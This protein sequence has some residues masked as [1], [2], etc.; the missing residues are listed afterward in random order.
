[1]LIE[2]ENK[3]KSL[4]WELTTTCNY[5]CSYCPD[6]AHD[7]KYRWP[8]KKH[9]DEILILIKKFSD[10]DVPL[11][12]DLLGGE[13]TLWPELPYFIS[14]LN[15]MKL[16]IICDIL[17]NGSRSIKWWENNVKL[18]DSVS[19]GLSFH[20]EYAK[21]DHFIEVI[22]ILK[23]TAYVYTRILALP[24]KWDIGYNFYTDAV[25]TIKTNLDIGFKFV[26]VNFGEE[27]YKYTKKQNDI[28]LS[29]SVNSYSRKL[30]E[31]RESFDISIDGEIYKWKYIVS[32]KLNKWK[33]MSCDAGLSRLFIN[34]VGDIY[35]ATC[36]SA[37]KIGNLDSYILPIHSQICK[38]D[39]CIC[40]SDAFARKYTT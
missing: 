34:R 1:M 4:T 25:S 22:N 38:S 37:I 24:E 40:L 27:L 7:G 33:N 28:I 14:R 21:S 31:S 39:V 3:I 19:F 8:S 20:P 32:N 30:K 11:M 15:D 6:D 23:N 10:D 13:P 9:V 16:N 29:S 35:T 18:F 5:K 12:I 2:S 26:R 36:S 17:S